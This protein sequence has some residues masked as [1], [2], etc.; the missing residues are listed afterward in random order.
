LCI[1][2]TIT[3]SLTTTTFTLTGCCGGTLTGSK[4]SGGDAQITGMTLNTT[5]R[6]CGG[7]TTCCITGGVI[8]FNL[9]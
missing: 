8:E 7:C 5:K 4:A 6:S 3:S 1:T 2:A 9:S